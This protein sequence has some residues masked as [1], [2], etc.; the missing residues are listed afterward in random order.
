MRT[1]CKNWN[2]L[3]PIDKQKFFANL[4]YETYNNINIGQSIVIEFNGTHYPQLFTLPPLL[5]ITFNLRLINLSRIN[6]LPNYEL[7]NFVHKLSDIINKGICEIKDVEEL[8]QNQIQP[9]LIDSKVIVI[10]QMRHDKY[11]YRYIGHRHF[12]INI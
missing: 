8:H 3:I 4:I 10:S 6:W 1:I 7:P 5:N 11:Q 2:T 9:S 12:Y